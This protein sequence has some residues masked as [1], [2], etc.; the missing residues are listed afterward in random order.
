MIILD[1]NVLSALISRTPDKE[2]I[3]WLDK[4]PRTSVWTTSVT[5]LEIRF[6]LQTMSLGKRRGALVQ[7]F[8]SVLADKIDRRIAPFDAAAAQ[9]AGDLMAVRHKK[10]RPGD[11][12]D[13][14]ASCWLFGLTF[15]CSLRSSGPACSSSHHRRLAL[16]PPLPEHTQIETAN[17]C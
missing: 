15:R 9:L 7:A 11:H 5:V 1:T 12:R 6:V 4:Q 17:E 3:L 14:M 10:G 16:T 13:T 2:V 8:E